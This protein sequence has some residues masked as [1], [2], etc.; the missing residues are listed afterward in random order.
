MGVRGRRGEQGPGAKEVR[1]QGASAGQWG[2]DLE[3]SATGTDICPS[4]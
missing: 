2:T 1:A 3:G 4:T